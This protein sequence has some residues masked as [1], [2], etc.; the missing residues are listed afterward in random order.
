MKQPEA[1]AKIG[2]LEWPVAGDRRGM[3]LY[4]LMRS[5]L[6]ATALKHGASV[7]V[8]LVLYILL[9]R[10]PPLLPSQRSDAVVWHLWWPIAL[11]VLLGTGGAYQGLALG[12]AGL[13]GGL[14]FLRGSHSLVRAGWSP[15]DTATRPLNL[16]LTAL[17]TMGITLLQAR[18][19]RHVDGLELFGCMV[20][21]FAG[22]VTAQ[23]LDLYLYRRTRSTL[24]GLNAAFAFYVL[25]RRSGLTEPVQLVLAAIVSLCLAVVLLKLLSPRYLPVETGEPPRQ[26]VL[27]PFRTID[28]S[29]AIALSLMT[30]ALGALGDAV[31]SALFHS[32]PIL[33]S[34]ASWFALL[35]AWLIAAE[36]FT[37]L[38]GRVGVFEDLDPVWFAKNMARYFWTLADVM[39]GS[40]TEAYLKRLLT[41]AQRWSMGV[42]VFGVTAAG[43]VLLAF[44]PLTLN[45]GMMLI[46]LPLAVVLSGQ[47]C[48]SLAGATW[49]ALRLSAQQTRTPLDFQ[50]EAAPRLSAEA[51]AP[52]QSNWTSERA[53][54]L[55]EVVI[56]ATER[57]EAEREKMWDLIRE[58]GVLDDPQPTRVLR[59]LLRVA[60]R[61]AEPEGDERLA[62]S[63]AIKRILKDLFLVSLVTMAVSAIV[64]KAIKASREGTIFLIM[65]TVFPFA[66][67][68]T[69]L[70]PA[71]RQALSQLVR[72]L[73]RPLGRATGKKR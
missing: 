24:L 37:R 65:G 14:M 2:A 48:Y 13:L 31:W 10:T 71:F 42:V 30:L 21:L 45:T 49:T 6:Q 19:T 67:G 73:I 59:A 53:H 12:S 32:D 72:D 1:A 16:L 52:L 9:V 38:N 20:V 3:D 55:A 41:L 22:S 25:L 5:L 23:L 63:Q 68:S 28:M 57:E 43:S 26:A 66:L 29:S 7:T 64:A 35:I 34:K 44:S 40:R 36:G 60:L 58:T 62:P 56:N 39:P 51:S 27:T 61:G 70:S 4:T 33:G 17:V 54:K 50:L 8:I 47:F 69:V 18:Y 46:V 15:W 11:L